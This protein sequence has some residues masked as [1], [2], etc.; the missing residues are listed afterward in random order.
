VRS[1]GG[2]QK[3]MAKIERKDA[4]DAIDEIIAVSDAVMVARGDLGSEFPLEEIPFIQARIIEK[5]RKA[6]KPVVTATEMLLSMTERERPTRA[7]VTDV[8]NAILQG[9]DAVMLSEETASGHYPALAVG[10]MEKIVLEAE[11]HLGKGHTVSPL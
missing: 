3:I 9:S 10:M 5:C 4:V 1:F 8:A 11:R 6:K 2:T 7:E